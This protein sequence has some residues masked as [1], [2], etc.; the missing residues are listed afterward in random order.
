MP[1][2]DQPASE[3]LVRRVGRLVRLPQTSSTTWHILQC[4]V[5]AG[6]AWLVA[7][8]LLHHDLPYFAPVT[9]TVGLGVS[10]D[11]RLRRVVEVCAGVTVGVVIASV[12]SLAVGTGPIQVTAMVAAAMALTLRWGGG[13]TLA[14]Q[15]CTQ[16]IAVST[17]T[18]ADGAVLDH[19]IDAGVGGVVALGIAVLRPPNPISLV[20]VQIARYLES[21]AAVVSDCGALV[22]APSPE[23]VPRID[24]TAN[25][26]SDA[27]SELAEAATE[28]VASARQPPTYKAMRE[29][30]ARVASMMDAL[31]EVTRSTQHMVRLTTTSVRRDQSPDPAWGSLYRDLATSL[32]TIAARIQSSGDLEQF[33]TGLVAVAHQT[34]DVDRRHSAPVAVAALVSI[35]SL[36]IDALILTGCTEREALR[37]VPGMPT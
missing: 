22:A 29:S 3:P 12:V 1:A 18:G 21:V 19:W 13:P 28:S 32:R 2:G 17:L 5:A 7:T 36:V 30:A 16:A 9:A 27:Y 35:R 20:R 25:D 14:L 10:F 4:S 11:R 24:N 15:A 37:L 26:L 23:A 33:R 6:I 31:D 8:E 34:L